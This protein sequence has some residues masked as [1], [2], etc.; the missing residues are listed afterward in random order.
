MWILLINVE[1]WRRLGRN[2]S[3]VLAIEAKKHF[4]KS[5]GANRWIGFSDRRFAVAKDDDK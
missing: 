1:S 4:E 5:W 3:H 2:L